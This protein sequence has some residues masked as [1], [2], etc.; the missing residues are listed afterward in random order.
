MSNCHR[1]FQSIEAIADLSTMDSIAGLQHGLI[2]T[3]MSPQ[4]AWTSNSDFLKVFG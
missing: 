3:L 4:E 2:M 1:V